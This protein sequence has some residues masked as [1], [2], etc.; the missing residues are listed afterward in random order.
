MTVLLNSECGCEEYKK[1]NTSQQINTMLRLV[2]NCVKPEGLVNTEYS[3]P[4]QAC[5]A[6][7]GDYEDPDRTAL[8]VEEPDEDA[9]WE[10]A[11]DFLPGAEAGGNEEG[12]CGGNEIGSR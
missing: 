8:P 12:V 10:A 1:S 3:N 6:C 2:E 5:S 4:L 7:A 9:E 11:R